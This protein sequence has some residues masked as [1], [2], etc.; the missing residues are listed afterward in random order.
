MLSDAFLLKPLEGL[1]SS[2]FSSI[3]SAFGLPMI[4][5][6]ADGAVLSGGNVIPFAK[7]GLPHGVYQSPQY[8]PMAG[9]RTGLMA[10]AGPEAI[11]PLSRGPD[12]KLGVQAQGMGGGNVII[13][14]YA[15]GDEKVETRRRRAGNNDEIDIYIGTA[16]AK[17]IASRGRMAQTM[18]AV[19]GLRRING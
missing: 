3:G 13:N 2:I 19:Y 11:M 6:A 14:V 9:G 16:G 5:A 8:F 7:G 18:E 12:G 4:G 1:F 15:S 17:D 10:E